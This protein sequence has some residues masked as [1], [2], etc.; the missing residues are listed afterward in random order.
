[1][2]ASFLQVIDTAGGVVHTSFRPFE[3]R[4]ARVPRQGLTTIAGRTDVRFI[5]QADQVITNRGR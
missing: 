1:M 2:V 4:R 3:A 5:R